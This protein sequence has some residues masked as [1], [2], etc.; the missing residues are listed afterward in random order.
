MALG[1]HHETIFVGACLCHIALPIA[2]LFQSIWS[3]DI[4]SCLVFPSAYIIL[5]RLPDLALYMQA[6][7][8][9]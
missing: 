3:H 9:L 1:E 5:S 6:L 4:A 7:R 2:S 8:R